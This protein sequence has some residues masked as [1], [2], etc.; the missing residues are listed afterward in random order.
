MDNGR[1]LFYDCQLIMDCGLFFYHW[2][3]K[4]DNGLLFTFLFFNNILDFTDLKLFPFFWIYGFGILRIFD[5]TDF[6]FTDFWFYRFLI[7]RI[8]DFTDFWFYGFILNMWFRYLP[9]Y[10]CNWN[11]RCSYV[12]D[13]SIMFL[14]Y[15][16][17]LCAVIL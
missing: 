9:L 4:M 11:L 13:I 17:S 3:S 2:Q 12:Y 5:F 6:F 8:F 10:F 7:L 16:W 1:G 15:K 14:N